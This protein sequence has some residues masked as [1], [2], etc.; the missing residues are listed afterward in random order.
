MKSPALIHKKDSIQHASSSAHRLHTTFT[1]RSLQNS[2]SVHL[3]NKHAPAHAHLHNSS[4]SPPQITTEL[5]IQEEERRRPP[6]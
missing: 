3:T 1:L 6:S 2:N 5:I 4:R